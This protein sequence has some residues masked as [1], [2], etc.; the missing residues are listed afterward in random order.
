MELDPA[1]EA[2]KRIL[3]E[4]MLI[5]DSIVSEEDAKLQLI[6]R[7]LCESLGWQVTDLRCERKHE[8]GYSDYVLSDNGVDAFVVEA[9]RLGKVALNS[10]DIDKVRRLKISGPALSGCQEGI[11]QAAAYANPDGLRM[12]VL[13]D[14]KTWIVYLPYV[15]GSKWKDKKAFVF[16]SF[17]AIL[18]D[19]GLFFDLLSKSQF[20][21]KI[22]KRAFDSIHEERGDLETPIYHPLQEREIKLSQ[23]SSLAFDLDRV[24][25]S[26]FS[27]ISGDDDAEMLIECFV[28]SEESRIADFSI[29]KMAANVLG[30]IVSK[31]DVDAKLRDLISSAVDVDSGETIFVVGPTGSGKSTFLDRF[32]SKSLDE[33]IKKRCIVL[34]IDCLDF[35]GQ[36]DNSL[37]WFTEQLVRRIEEELFVDGAPS[38]ED[39]RGLYHLEYLRRIKGPD[40]KLYESSKDDFYLK[41]SEIVEELV[42]KDRLGY[43]KKLL[44]DIV[45]NRKLLPVMV[46]DNTD[47]FETSVKSSIFQYAQSIRRDVNHCLLIFPLTDKSA[48]SFSKTDLYGIYQSKSFFLPTPPPR[49]IFRRR[50]DYLR[51]KIKANEFQKDG[52]KYFAKKGIKI[53][54]DDLGKFAGV[55]EDIF[56]DQE[57]AAR[58]LGELTNY[59]IRRM[60]LL[61]R[62]VITSSIFDVDGVVKSYVTG[63][64]LAPSFS[65]FMNA[66]LRGDYESF[67]PSDTHEILNVFKIDGAISHSLLMNLR[68]L[69]LL[70]S[71]RQEKRDIAERHLSVQSIFSYF[72]ALGASEASI[73]RSLLLLLQARLIEPYDSSD[74]LLSPAQRFAISHAGVAH[75]RLARTSDVFF[76]QMA[77]ISGFRRED[78][79][80]KLRDLFK[81]KGDFAKRMGEV[82]SVFAEEI[83]R[84]D[85]S[86]LNHDV[87]LPQHRN[88]FELLRDIS[89]LGGAVFEGGGE[90]ASDSTNSGSVVQESVLQV[91]WFDS[92]KG[93]GF[94]RGDE[95]EGDIFLHANQLSEAEIAS[96]SEGD[97][98]R[99][100]IGTSDRGRSVKHVIELISDQD[101]LDE[102]DCEVIR[103]MPERG[104]GFARVG[105]RAKDAYFSLS[106]FEDGVRDQLAMGSKFRAT[107]SSDSVG[108]L[109]ARSIVG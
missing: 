63:E 32:F 45:N 38:W 74:L 53:S 62:R 77:F 104:F 24:L 43:L 41:F 107:I 67:R 65:K 97:Y 12:A 1:F 99:C 48:W 10:A 61:C 23:K 56:V 103:L 72:D 89:I 5:I 11:E 16:P 49:E 31:S 106:I 3:D 21:K 28:D 4:A 98:L 14:G 18:H 27:R 83:R 68:I 91:V 58:T 6:Q 51:R 82:R 2:A 76:E 64:P 101:G 100:V 87:E 93:Y 75:L 80:L 25:T 17:E 30:N 94:V 8:N 96:V 55:V 13:T 109:R 33:S 108:R 79:A 57:Y 86:F 59:N 73:D 37:N 54:I 92:Q 85:R 35:G 60:L 66:L 47:E 52:G 42:E 95:Q 81:Q 19:F 90:G 88:Q 105:G 29:E 36:I 70:Y 44:S 7:L 78:V 26:F 22:Y 46:F 102:F 50:I 39:L 71:I 15:P 34:K 40:Q 69:S 20:R 9:K 84:D